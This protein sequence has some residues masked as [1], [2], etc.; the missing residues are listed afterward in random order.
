MYLLDTVA[1]SESAKLNTDSSYA[2]F[3]SST[4]PDSKLISVAS[5]AEI[6]YGLNLLPDGKRKAELRIWIETTEREFID[7]TLGV[8]GQL[9]VVWGSVRAEIQKQGFTIAYTDLLIAATAL[10]HDLTVVTH[11]VKDFEPTGCKLLNPWE[12]TS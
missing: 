7:R 11:N 5:V 6:R 3:I 4:T 12:P 1:L 9:A 8:D 2:E 10:H